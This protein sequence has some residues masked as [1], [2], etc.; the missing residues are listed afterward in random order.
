VVAALA[1]AFFLGGP[2]LLPFGLQGLL[3]PHLP[4]FLAWLGEPH[5]LF[6]VA[7]IIFLLFVYIWVRGTIPRYRYDQV[8]A[9]AWKYLIPLALIN[10]LLAAAV[11]YCA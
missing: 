9:V 4:T 3:N 5:A 7:K 1:S 10:L 6:F 2:W 8:M 11:R